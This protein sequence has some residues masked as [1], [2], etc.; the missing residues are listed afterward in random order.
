MVYP[1][2]VKRGE[3]R[4]VSSGLLIHFH[5]FRVPWPFLCMTEC[6]ESISLEVA[7]VLALAGIHGIR[8]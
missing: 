8:D 5:V 7:S 2:F 3:G 6:G 1:S 4:F